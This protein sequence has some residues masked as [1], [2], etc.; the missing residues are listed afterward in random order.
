MT[1]RRTLLAALAFTGF[2]SIGG[3]AAQ[4]SSS[5]LVT[6][7]VPGPPGSTPDLLA[8]MLAERLR[9]ILGQDFIIENRPGAGGLIG[10]EFVARASP[11][12][13]TLLCATEWV[14]FS[15]LLN[16][17]LNFD[18]H[19]FAPVGIIAR[20]PL[21]LIGRKDLPVGDIAEM[22]C[23]ARANPGKLSYASSG[24]G[25][26]HQLVYEAIKKQ[27]NI[28]LAHVPYRG[29]PPAMNDLLAGHVDVSLTS[30]NQAAPL[31]K[32]GKLKLLA[33]VGGARLTEFPDAPALTE[34]L[35][36]LE[37]DAWSGMV[38]PPRTPEAITKRVSDAIAQVLRM[39]DVRARLAELLLEPVGNTPDE[40]QAI[41]RK[42]VER[43]APVV[44]AAKI[45]IN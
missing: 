32:E 16:S 28:D 11:D 29:G 9:Q 44:T 39:P 38:A 36:G 22:I 33:I 17:K 20:Y 45:T 13:N 37:A 2:A 5:R 18:P 15:H 43:W 23:Y 12:G 30:L 4:P 1:S 41:M 25:S 6:V 26:M 14:F 21:V 24:I 42:D 34:V 27:A 3:A 19:A 10:A 8:R 7:V 40:M 35:P 31:I